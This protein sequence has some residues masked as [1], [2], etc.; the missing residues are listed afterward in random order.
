V[1]AREAMDEALAAAPV[2]AL[3]GAGRELHALSDSE[4]LLAV[5][6]EAGLDSGDAR[7]HVLHAY[8]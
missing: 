3:V 4:R 6:R 2:V 5:L 7:L 1:A 8:P